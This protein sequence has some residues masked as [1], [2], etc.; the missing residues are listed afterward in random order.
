[1]KVLK[2]KLTWRNFLNA[3]LA[4]TGFF[5]IDQPDWLKAVELFPADSQ[6]AKYVGYALGVLS[7]TT[8]FAR[9]VLVTIDTQET[10]SSPVPNPDTTEAVTEELPSSRR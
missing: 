4:T 9:R 10:S 6:M 5:L 7:F 2:A 8:I 1:M 3:L